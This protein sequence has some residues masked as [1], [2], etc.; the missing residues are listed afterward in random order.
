MGFNSAFKGLM[1]TTSNATQTTSLAAEP[2]YLVSITGKREFSLLRNVQTCS[3]VHPASY[4]MRIE[5]FIPH[6]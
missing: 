6:G 4:S 2:S 1:E 3:G 5:S